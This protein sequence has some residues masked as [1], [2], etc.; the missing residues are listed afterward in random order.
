MKGKS[1]ITWTL[2]I[3]GLILAFVLSSPLWIEKF[4][5]GLSISI[6]GSI[7]STSALIIAVIEINGIKE[8][9]D[10]I[11]QAVLENSNA[12]HRIGNVYDVARLVQMIYEIQGMV[13]AEKWEMAHLRM[14]ELFNMLNIINSNVEEYGIGIRDIERHIKNISSDLKLLNKAINNYHILSPVDI[15]D[16]LDEV[17]PLLT[18]ICT[19]LKTQGNDN[20]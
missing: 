2:I 12:I 17:S 9:N 5:W 18:R 16:H 8:A 14:L 1:A 20:Q 6:A 7:I 3:G 4:E 15:L 11:Q 13:N 10:A 19:N